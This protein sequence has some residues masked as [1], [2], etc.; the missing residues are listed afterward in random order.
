MHTGGAL[1]FLTQVYLHL[2]V[3]EALASAP[4]QRE[5]VPGH[6]QQGAGTVSRRGELRC[7][8]AAKTI[9]PY[10]PV[11]EGWTWTYPAFPAVSAGCGFSF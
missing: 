1:R 2:C 9:H 11:T 6:G 8:E 3:L 4:L 10:T 7:A 5:V